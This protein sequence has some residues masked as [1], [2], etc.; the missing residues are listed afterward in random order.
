MHLF[1]C[2]GAELG[3]IGG[4]EFKATGETNEFDGSPGGGVGEA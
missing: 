4:N 3:E 1:S 2:A